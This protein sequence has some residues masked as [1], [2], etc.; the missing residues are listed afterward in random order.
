MDLSVLELW[1]SMGLFAQAIV[2]VLLLMSIYT[3]TIGIRKGVQLR[4]SRKATLAFSPLFSEALAKQDLRE[5][6]RLV[7]AYPGSHLAATFR[8]VFPSLRLDSQDRP[9]P[10]AAIASVQRMTELN[11]LE[12]LAQFRWGLGVLATTG[13][14]APFV[15]LLGTV[16]GVVNAFTGMAMSGSGG[17][18]A[19]SR[20]IAEALVATGFGLLVA[21]P[22]VWM[23]NYYVNRIEFISMEISYATK[24]F[25]DFLLRH[26]AWLPGDGVRETEEMAGEPTRLQAVDRPPHTRARAR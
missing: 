7:E 24:E 17:L 16:V 14:T 12:Q 22:A 2:V 19:I 21:I 11:T 23:Y 8:R 20:G 26:E 25:I 1:K 10:E 6:E 13:S 5:A 9:S 18:A 15:G 4:R 3:A